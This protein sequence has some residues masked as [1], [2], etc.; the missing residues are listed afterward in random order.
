MTDETRKTIEMLGR[1]LSVYPWEL[2]GGRIVYSALGDVEGHGERS[3][4]PLAMMAAT[5]RVDRINELMRNPEHRHWTDW[6]TFTRPAIREHLKAEDA[7]REPETTER[8]DTD[9]TA[10]AAAAAID[11]WP[12]STETGLILDL[13]EDTVNDIVEAS[14]HADSETGRALIRALDPNREW[15]GSMFET[16]YGKLDAA[17]QPA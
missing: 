12:H 16:Y 9:A 10:Y 15:L 5:R 3:F 17:E 4:S 2:E 6:V 1:E 8:L 13:D 11:N 7:H 14:D